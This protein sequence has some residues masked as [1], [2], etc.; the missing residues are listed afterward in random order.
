MFR[1]NVKQLDELLAPLLRN[2]GLETP[3]LQKRLIDN[4]RLVAGPIAD[5]YTGD[6]YIKNQTLMVQIPNAALRAD[7]NMRRKLLVQKLNASVG[8]MIITDI[9]FF[10][11]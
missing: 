8:A 11:G 9:H 1:R 6:V 4:W 3:L 7:L 10:A 2:Q 5:R